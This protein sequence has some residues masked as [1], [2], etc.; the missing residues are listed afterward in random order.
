MPYETKAT[1]K[2]PAFI[3]YLIDISGSMT[4]SLDGTAKIE[5]VHGALDDVFATMVRRS[6]RGNEVIADRYRVAI[7]AYSDQPED[8]FG[9]PVG[10]SRIANLKGRLRFKAENATDT[11]AA[12]A[13]AKAL[14]ERELPQLAHCPAPM[15]CH[16]TDGR[17]T[18]QDPEPL[19]Q[20]IMGLSVPDGAVLIENVYVGPDLTRAPIGDAKSWPG[21]RD[22]AELTDEYAQKL[23]RMSSPLP[24]SYSNMLCKDGYAIQPGAR[25]LV[26]GTS[27]DLVR[28]AFAVSGATEVAR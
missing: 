11:W 13:A 20:E 25:M 19:A 15:I 6:R 22:V 26:P 9:G 8:A 21:L 3:I 1:Q 12:F 5:H 10:V 4:E 7:L 24:P 23:F 16:L 17:F 2:T 14:L 18:G 28:L 27:R